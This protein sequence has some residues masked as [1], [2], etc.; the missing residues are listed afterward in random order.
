MENVA[1]DLIQLLRYLL[2]G[3][4]SAWVF[5][6]FTSFIKPSQF[7]RVVQALIFTLIVQVCVFSYKSLALYLSKYWVI[8][9]WNKDA[10]LV[11]SVLL[12]AILGFVFAY[13]AN[14]DKFHSVVRKLGVSR[15]TSYPSEWFGEFSNK[16]TY[17]V[18]HLDGERRLYGWPKEWPSSPDKGHFS[19]QQA[20]W[21]N[22][23]E[24][25]PLAGVETI[26]IPAK[27]VQMVEFMKKTWEE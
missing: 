15:E 17:V 5:Y 27:D 2:P 24:E 11:V 7:E 3:F 10:E 21:L 23:G 19:I 14:S 8:G 18:L 25:I 4:L 16:I 12:A 20:S 13:F 1:S 22:G 6:E 9:P 26:L